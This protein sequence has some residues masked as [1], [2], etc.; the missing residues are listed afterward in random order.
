VN[1]IK[2]TTILIWLN[3]AIDAGHTLDIETVRQQAEAGTLFEWL[4]KSL[5]DPEIL[6][7]VNDAD[8]AELNQEWSRH[9]NAVS[10]KRKFNVSRTGLSLVLTYVAQSIQ[11][12]IG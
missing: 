6:S 10:S 4:V 5:P 9:E 2:L 12:R 11:N 1:P 7:F 8:R 3:A